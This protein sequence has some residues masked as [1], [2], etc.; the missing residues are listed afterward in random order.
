MQR[1][2]GSVETAH[3]KAVNV[4]IS[5][6]TRTLQEVLSRKVTAF[7]TNVRDAK[8]ITRWANGETLVV[9]P[10]NE[11][12]LRAAYEIAS[13]L[14]EE[15]DSPQTVRAWFLGMN[16]QLGDDS[17]AQAIRDGRFKEALGAAKAFVVG[18]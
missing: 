5:D 11:Q 10:E 17:P 4:S 8:T 1:T 6:A 3:R 7:T 15:G 14:L 13:L 2:G 12:R 18:G 9:L 16:P